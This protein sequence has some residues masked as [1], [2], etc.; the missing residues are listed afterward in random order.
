MGQ[1]ISEKLN[2]QKFSNFL[3]LGLVVLG[4][5]FIFALVAGLFVN[6]FLVFGVFALVLLVYV[7]Y[8]YPTLGL[9]V[10]TLLFPFWGLSLQVGSINLPYIDLVGASLFLALIVHW[11]MSFILK[12]RDEKVDKQVVLLQE[13]PGLTYAMLFWL[14]SAMAM[15][16]NSEFVLALKYLVRPIMFFY[17]IYVLLP[18]NLIKSKK[19]FVKVLYFIFAGGIITSILGLLS[20]VLTEGSLYARRAV[21][22]AF[23]NWNLL[24]GN[25]NAVAE[26]LVVA[27]P[28]GIILY[29]LQKNLKYQGWILVM[30][31]LMMFVLLLTFS[32]SGWLALF[33]E[34]L[35]IFWVLYRKKFSVY[36]LLIIGLLAI[37]IIFLFYLV[38]WHNVTMVQGSTSSRWLMSQISWYYFLENPIIGNGLNTFSELVGSTFVYNVEFGDPLDSHGLVQK[39]STESGI[40]GLLTYLG[41]L[42]FFVRFYIERFKR[43]KDYDSR[44]VVL[45][46]I[47]IVFGALFFQ[48]F[49]T[50]YYLAKLWLPIGLAYA[51]IKLYS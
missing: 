26:V 46:L 7:F 41:L 2:K 49:S 48:F 6:W 50:S 24:G 4:L 21:P 42:G 35:I 3:E 29:F 17:L 22:Y 38:I 31:M 25:H 27:V 33:F 28:V 30:T 39:L 10:F 15:T 16:S 14:V 23:G 44:F 34:F 32:R 36:N 37:L 11:L 1:V 45:L 5:D 51:G 8:F 19:V 47:V 9:Y 18:I 12:K 40:L 43:I 13:F 20:V